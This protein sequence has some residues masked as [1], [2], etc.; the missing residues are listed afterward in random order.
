MNLLRNLGVTVLALIL[1]S[2]SLAE[3]IKYNGSVLTPGARLIAGDADKNEFYILGK[4]DP[5]P[6]KMVASNQVPHKV[7]NKNSLPHI[8]T[9]LYKISRASPNHKLAYKLNTI[10][11]KHPRRVASKNQ[12]TKVK[13]VLHKGAHGNS[14]KKITTARVSSKLK[15][16]HHKLAKAKTSHKAKMALNR[17][18]RKVKNIASASK[19]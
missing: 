7:M 13:I 17:G 2:G 4:N 8:K 1:S 19:V 9:V 11:K 10:L 5:V 14:I 12:V 15:H 3:T 6:T 18:H 16:F